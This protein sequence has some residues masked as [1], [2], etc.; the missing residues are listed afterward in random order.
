MSNSTYTDDDDLSEE[1]SG[2]LKTVTVILIVVFP[3]FML[4]C[5]SLTSLLLVQ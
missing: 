5:Q 1:L 2:P 3:L 4:Y